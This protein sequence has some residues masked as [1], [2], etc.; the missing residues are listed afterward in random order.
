MVGHGS[1]FHPSLMEVTDISKLTSLLHCGISYDRKSF[2]MQAPGLIDK[3]ETYV[4]TASL[5][6]TVL[7][8]K[9]VAGFCKAVLKSSWVGGLKIVIWSHLVYK[10]LFAYNPRLSHGQT[11]ANRTKPGPNVI[12]LFAVVISCHSMVIQSFCVIKQHYLGNYCW[13]AVF[14]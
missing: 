5:L 12:K 3:V 13:T 6:S 11:L 9:V 14:V 4:K 2:I 7:L 8:P 1:H 10:H